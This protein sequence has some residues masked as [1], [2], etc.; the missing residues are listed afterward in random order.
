MVRAKYPGV[1]ATYK[2]LKGGARKA[3]WY[4]RAT[5]MRLEG[6]PG[7]PG[8]QAFIMSYAEAERTLKARHSGDT[9][10]G[11]AREF[12]ASPEFEKLSASTQ[13]EYKRRL[14]KAEPV[15]GDLPREALNE[16]GVRRDFLDWRATVARS[17]GE[18]EADNRLSVISAMLTW[19]QEN[20][21]IEANHI[22]GF[23]RLYH[24]DRAEIVWL[25]EHIDAFMRVAPIELQRSLIIALQTGQRQA[26]ILRLP[27]SAYDGSAITLRQGKSARGG[28]VA[29]LSR[30]PARKRSGGCWT[31]WSADR[32]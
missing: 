20:G 24:A 16:P 27:W 23:K 17:S 19:G 14:A 11:L 6:E 21:R 30:S 3:Y 28:R 18:R 29:P 12:T 31:V 13:R 1:F 26:D 10:N 7:E 32:R 9:F 8:E 2:P 5:G 15:F 25:P 4:H 22:R